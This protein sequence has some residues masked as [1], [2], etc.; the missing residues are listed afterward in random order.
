MTILYFTATGNNLYIAKRIGGELVSIPQ[1]VKKGAY[2]FSDDKI[3]IVFPVYGWAVPPYV[4]AFLRKA[5]LR[6]NYLFA[7]LSYG[8]L[9]GAACTHLATIAAECDLHFAYINTL[10]MVDNYVPGFDMRKQ[11]ETIPKKR[12]DKHLDEMIADVQKCVHRS[13]K[14]SWIEK[15]MT[16]RL[17]MASQFAIGPGVAKGFSVED[18]C[19]HCG[20]CA[21]VCPTDNIVASDAKPTFGDECLSCL[22]CTQ[23]CPQNAIRVVGEKSRERFRNGHITLTEI[24][25]ANQ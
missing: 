14:D 12:I 20:T 13:P 18:S 5:T 17:H 25:K 22:A 19:T 23:N 4:E 15:R 3:G 6:S 1:A 10:K 21:K 16:K 7:I 2:D 8:M 11:L 9:D 24:V